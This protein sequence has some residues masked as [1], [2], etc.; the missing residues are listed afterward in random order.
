MPK[1]K[2]DATSR[3]YALLLR[4]LPSRLRSRAA[5][6]ML[7]TFRERQR[8]ARSKGRSALVRVWASELAGLVVVAVRAR[9]DR[10][11]VV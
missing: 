7:A 4:L 10:K 11:S 3:F 8:E 2:L 6:E 5:S 9:R 1:R